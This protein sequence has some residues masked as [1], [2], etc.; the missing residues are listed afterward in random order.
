MK[1]TEFLNMKHI[2]IF[3]IFLAIMFFAA[4]VAYLCIGPH[5]HPMAVV[6][7]KSQI[8]LSMITVTIGA[9]VVW[10]LLTFLFGRIYCSTV[11]PIGSITDFFARLGR[12]LPRRRKTFR[13][14]SRNNWGGYILVI[15]ILCLLL[16]IFSVAFVIEPWNIMRNIASIVRP[17]AVEL[18][19]IS[20]GV[21]AGV[22]IVAGIVSLLILIIWSMVSGRD[23][24]NTACPIGAALGAVGHSALMHI[25][26][27]PDRCTYC[28]RCEEICSAHCIKVTDRRVD[29][30]RCL[31][32][33]DCLAVCDDDAIH[34][35]LNNNIPLTPLFRKRRQVN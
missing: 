34:F 24:C 16:G 35:Q 27:D 22:G 26:I 4:A 7:E 9:T 14:K 1:H 12:K 10:L 11:C 6:S 32:C 21:G 17:D 8:I 13:W 18:S 29:N 31:R 2:R 15:Y 3:R 33:F 5:A 19:W 30:A 20:L 25:E 23:F 28:G